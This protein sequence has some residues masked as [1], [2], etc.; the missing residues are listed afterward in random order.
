MPSLFNA[1]LTAE[2]SFNNP[3]MSDTV[4][5]VLV[6]SIYSASTPLLQEVHQL[7]GILCLAQLADI[8]EL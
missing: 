6:A 4:D 2:F 1:R 3:A 5:F 7:A 8:L